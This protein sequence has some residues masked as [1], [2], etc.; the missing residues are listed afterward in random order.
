MKELIRMENVTKRYPGVIALK[1]VSVSFK[2]GEIHAIIGENGAGK[3]TLMKVLSGAVSPSSGLIIVDG[4]EYRRLLPKEAID[5]GIQVVYQELN[6]IGNMS[7]MDNVFIGMPPRKGILVDKKEM[8]RRTR[9]ILHSI[10]MDVISPFEAVERLTSGYQQ[11]VEIA[12]ALTRKVRIL[13][14][15]EPTSA[16]SSAEAD[17]L[18]SVVEKLKR[19]GVTVLFISHRLE[20]IFRIADRVTV[21]RDGEVIATRDI[22]AITRSEMINMMVGRSFTE[23]YPRSGAA[24]GEIVLEVKNISGAGFKNVS[25]SLRQGEILGFGGLVGSGRTET[26][27]GIFGATHI[28]SGEVCIHGKKHVMKNPSD[29]IRRGMAL[30]PEN[31]KE[32]GLILSLP[33]RNNIDLPSLKR[34]SKWLVINKKKDNELVEESIAQLSIKTPSANQVVIN[35]SGGN[36]QKVVVAKWL[37]A[38]SDILIFDEP[39][40]GIDVASKKEIYE[41]MCDLARD[42]KA[43]ILISS[44]MEELIGVSDRLEIFYEGTI[45]GEIHSYEE[46]DRNRIMEYASGITG[47]A[48]GKNE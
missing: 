12:K 3:S 42:G 19:E 16:L 10:G 37:G 40:K 7:V 11:M 48:E 41:L 39:T 28:N 13:V 31:R 36:Q 1:D 4:K 47:A 46:F 29:S 14:L 32:Q 23:V 27:M 9:E 30:L 43:I 35:L 21:M 24:V 45:S 25:F 2:K 38:E 44:D 18:F 33:I 6:Q 20:E 17:I 15:D 34:I 26:I 5:L 22:R 8:E